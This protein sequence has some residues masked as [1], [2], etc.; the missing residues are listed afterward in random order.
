MPSRV[1]ALGLN[2]TTTKL[3]L[4]HLFEDNTF[5][6][7]QNFNSLFLLHL[8]SF[9]SWALMLKSLH[10]KVCLPLSPLSYKTSYPFLVNSNHLIVLLP[11]TASGIIRN[12]TG[13][14]GF[15]LWQPKSS[16]VLLKTLSGF[17]MRTCW[18]WL[19]IKESRQ[20]TAARAMHSSHSTLWIDTS[21]ALFP[22]SILGPGTK[23]QKHWVWGLVFFLLNIT[24][25]PQSSTKKNKNCD[26]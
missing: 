4:F 22:R 24:S 11:S 9:P 13:V 19:D 10:S 7:E 12:K 1:M 14:G 3:K 5:I 17:Y 25:C 20:S 8:L 18:R 23:R 16:F 2:P 21:C 26:F 15:E 6:C